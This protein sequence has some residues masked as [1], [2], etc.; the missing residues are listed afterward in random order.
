MVNLWYVYFAIIKESECKKKTP[1]NLKRY[2][3]PNV[4]ALCTVAKTWK[5]PRQLNGEDV[6]YIHTTEYD[7]ARK[8][9]KY[10]HLQQCGRT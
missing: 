5:P 1:Q 3:H 6:K 2:M 10:C 9:M 8:R 4:A 7:S